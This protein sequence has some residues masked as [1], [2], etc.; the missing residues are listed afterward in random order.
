MSANR[1]VTHYP[2][3]E[4]IAR[5]EP[6]ITSL[7]NENG[8]FGVFVTTRGESRTGIDDEGKGILPKIPREAR[9]P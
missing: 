3:S 1:K 4:K 7:R 9:I 8:S 5:F 2:E 6:E